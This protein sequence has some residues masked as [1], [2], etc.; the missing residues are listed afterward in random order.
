MRDIDVGKVLPHGDDLGNHLVGVAQ[1]LAGV[2]QD[3]VPLPIE[4]RGVAVEAEVAVE[5]HSVLQ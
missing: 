3:R 1:E 4:Q 2:D 5:K